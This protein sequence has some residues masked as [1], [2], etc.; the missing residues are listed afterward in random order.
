M[1]VTEILL[2]EH[3][4]INQTLDKILQ[5]LEEATKD[6]LEEWEKF[7]NFVAD[8]ADGVHHKK[9]EDNYFEWMR[10]KSPE[11]DQ[12]PLKCMLKDHDT[13]REVIKSS[14]GHFVEFKVGNF[15]NEENF[16]RLIGYYIQILQ[17]HI[18]KENF[19]LFKF[20]ESLDRKFNDGDGLMLPK[21]EEIGY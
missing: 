6:N 10:Q 1:K 4:I 16:K 19:I 2:K 14:K 21:F 7:Y 13:F 8:Y 3:E 9:E 11:L 5:L 20:A 17:D 15:E 12:G 18:N